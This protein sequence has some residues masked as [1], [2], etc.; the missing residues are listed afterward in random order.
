M[1]MSM[2]ATDVAPNRAVRA[3]RK[4]ID[5]LNSRREEG[6]TALVVYAG[7]AHAVTPLTDDVETIN[8][9]VPSPQP[10]IM[11][12]LAASRLPVSILP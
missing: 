8:N 5:V 1:S 4:I 7:D 2:Y 10:N 6:Q 11:P 3:Q 9:L 12:V